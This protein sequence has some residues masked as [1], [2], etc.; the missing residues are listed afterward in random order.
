MEAA[1][2]N[3]AMGA[4]L[5]AGVLTSNAAVIGQGLDSDSI[6]EPVRGPLIPG[7]AAVKAAARAA[8]ACLPLMHVRLRDLPAQC[9]PEAGMVV[10][11]DAVMPAAGVHGLII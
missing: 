8:G 6:I 10:Q 5:V 3:G 7:F 4:T 2:R 11:F 9:S 1:I